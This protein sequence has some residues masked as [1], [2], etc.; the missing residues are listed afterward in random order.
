MCVVKKYDGNEKVIKEKRKIL[1]NVHAIPFS[2]ISEL[3]CDCYS[4]MLPYFL[5]FKINH[6]YT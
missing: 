4:T 5:K 6:H 3:K 1:T 2:D